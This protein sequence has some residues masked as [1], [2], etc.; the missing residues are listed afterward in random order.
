MNMD[1]TQVPQH[2]ERILQV[3]RTRFMDEGFPSAELRR[4]RLDKLIQMIATHHQQIEEAINTDFGTRAKDETLALEVFACID[5][6]R[7]TRRHLSKWMKDERRPVSLMSWPGRNRLI[8]QP[9][10]V[11][12]IVV[13]WN[14][15]LY[16]AVSPLA[17]ALAAGNRAM[18]KMSEFTPAFSALFADLIAQ[19]F[20]ASEVAVIQGGPEVAT[21]FTA[22]PFDHILFTGSTTV[23]KMVMKAAAPN[24][25]PV[26][27]ELGGKS[28][29]LIAEDFPLET[30]LTRILFGK[31]CNAGQT[32]LSPD[33]LL[34]PQ[35]REAEFLQC[36]KQ[37]TM[38]Y[39]ASLQGNAEYTSIVNDRQAQRL[40]G[41]LA[42]A[43]SKGALLAPLH[44]EITPADS[45]QMTP[46]AVFNVSDDMRVMQ[47][48]LF[49]PILP[50]VTYRDTDE[51]I[52]YVN[53][54]P[55]P[56]ALYVFS[57]NR[58]LV[59]K[60]LRS[61]TSGGAVVN[62]VILH[63]IQH[64]M[65]FGGVGPSGMGRYHGKEGFDTF[66]QVKSVFEQSRFNLGFLLHP[67]RLNGRLRRV[68]KRMIRA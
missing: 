62:D 67:P 9:L 55:C 48:E 35:G 41:I 11:I 12:G 17:G 50:V 29:T 52:A 32:C 2:M 30:A 4:Q 57:H 20:T 1:H 42:D 46:T 24:L 51:A 21:H 38:R 49:G 66:S 31:L 44:D 23:G 54:H 65:P 36:A 26:T 34:L 22:L 39:Y 15:P 43:Q 68:M 8:R 27:L 45:R 58:P 28:P 37:I 13:P 7:H 60:V 53:A 56:L 64:D 33:Y 63:V 5:E 16:L 6:L 18:V 59:E 40:R 61:T 3:Q 25:T 47:E 14:Y 10:G 19:T